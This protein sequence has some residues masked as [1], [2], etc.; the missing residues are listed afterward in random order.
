M[1]FVLQ[2]CQIEL[3]KGVRSIEVKDFVTVRDGFR[4]DGSD[5]LDGE[6]LQ[7]REGITVGTI[8]WWRHEGVGC[9]E[10]MHLYQHRAFLLR[11]VK[12]SLCVSANLSR[13]SSDVLLIVPICVSSCQPIFSH[14]GETEAV[15]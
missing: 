4:A 8:S 14:I 10:Q 1:G 12:A 11:R 2:G 9:G 13:K 7:K 5:P 3:V 6:T 15:Q